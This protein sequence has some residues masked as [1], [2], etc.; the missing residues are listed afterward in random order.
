MALPM[1]IWKLFKFDHQ[2][3]E[4]LRY[5]VRLVEKANLLPASF[6]STYLKPQKTQLNVSNERDMSNDSQTIT[7]AMNLKQGVDDTFTEFHFLIL[8]IN[9]QATS[10]RTTRFEFKTV[11]N[12]FWKTV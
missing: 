9:G 3:T 10:F 4:R 1:Q 5:D 6:S 7:P 12:I 11:K 2:V 8:G